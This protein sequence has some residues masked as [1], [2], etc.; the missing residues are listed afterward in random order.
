MGEKT[1]SAVEHASASRPRG[2]DGAQRVFL[3]SPHVPPRLFKRMKC[4]CKPRSVSLLL[5]GPSRA[6]ASSI[7]KFKPSWRSGRLLCLSVS[8]ASGSPSRSG[9]DFSAEDICACRKECC[10]SSNFR[11]LSSVHPSI[12]N[13]ASMFPRHF[14]FLLPHPMPA[15]LSSRVCHPAR[16]FPRAAAS[17]NPPLLPASPAS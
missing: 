10:H 6:K 4:N 12:Y 15:F 3:P 8:L 16:P 5:L 17:P 2:W 1:K 14:S 13:T 11:N 9:L 7:G